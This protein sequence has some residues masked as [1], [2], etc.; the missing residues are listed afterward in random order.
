MFIPSDMLAASIYK[1]SNG[2]LEVWVTEDCLKHP[3]GLFADGKN[4]LVA[5]WGTPTAD[6][7]S[8]EVPGNIKAISMS[9]KKGRDMG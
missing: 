5:N 8:T 9:T 3:N 7:W 2:K 4:L 6:D 1:L